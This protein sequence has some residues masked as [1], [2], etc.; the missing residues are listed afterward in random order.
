M[1]RHPCIYGRRRNVLCIKCGKE[2]EVLC[3]LWSSAGDSDTGCGREVNFAG[4]FEA[5]ILPD[6]GKEKG[7]LIAA[8]VSVGLVVFCIV[9]TV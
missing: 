4:G 9:G 2:R 6:A 3:I 8:L 7:G 5:E 1:G